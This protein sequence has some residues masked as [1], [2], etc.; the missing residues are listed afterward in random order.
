[1]KK[2]IG[3][4]SQ[5][6]PLTDLPIKGPIQDHTMEII[7][8]GGILV[9]NGK[10]LKI[11]DFQKIRES[12]P[13]VK[14]EEVNYPAVL[15]PGFIDCH[16]HIC[17]AG[18][19][20]EEYAMRSWGK[21]YLE[22]SEAGGGIWNTVQKTR[23]E[24]AG[25]LLEDLIQRANLSLK[26]GI[27]TLEVK[28]GYG[29][30]INNELKQLRVIEEANKSI[31]IDLI[32]TCLAA[33][34]KP[35][36]FEGSPKEYLNF[37]LKE[38]L[39]KVKEENLS[40]R[41]DIFIEKTA[42][43]PEEALPYLTAAHFMGFDIT[44]HADQFNSGG[45]Q[46]AYGLESVSVD[47]L[48]SIN[49]RDILFLARS[50]TVGVVLPGS[51]LGLGNPFAPARKILNQGACLAIA[52]DWNPGS[53][54]MGDLLVGASLLGAYE[55]L[56]SAEVFAG[57]TFRAALALNLEDRG[58]LFPGKLADFQA[59]PCSDYRE[60]LYHQGKMKAAQVWKKGKLID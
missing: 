40:K 46:V 24:Q 17:F 5:I 28:S 18:T 10:I 6:L 42:F 26:D 2:I 13:K 55:K 57:L 12:H 44:M 32:S 45:S 9:E 43:S 11:G 14:I 52:S 22:I 50:S 48:E 20:S 15:I 21:T 29:L 49:D 34:V 8:Q 54:P 60:I 3:P 4:F 58:I 23:A 39:P 25:K 35:R 51:S 7:H 1:M 37:L 47:H 38:L 16:T 33:H 31:P 19:R 36:D 27:T 41:V 56:S 59:F 30:D 53:S